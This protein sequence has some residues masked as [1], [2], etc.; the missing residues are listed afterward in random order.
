MP[1]LGRRELL[2][3]LAVTGALTGAGGLL[4]ACGHSAANPAGAA[5]SRTPNRGGNLKIGMSGGSSSDTLDPHQ[6]LT[7][8]DTG[9]FEALYQPLV[10]LSGTAAIEY[11]LAESITPNHG[12]LSEWIIKIRPGVAFHSGKD[13]TADDVV[14]TIQRIISKGFSGAHFFGPTDLKNVK[15]LDKLTVQVPMA[16]PFG[17]FVDQLAGGWYYLYVVPSGFDG[18][19]P[20]GTGPF[21]FQSF[22]P[23]QR[24]VFV[25]N[26]N[27]WKHGLPYA[28][29]LTIIDFSDNAAVQDALVT[30]SIQAAG[31]LD[32][33]Q[34]PALR[35]AS[36]VR[37]VASRTGQFKPFTMRIDQAPFNDVNVRQALR[38][39][40]DRQQL[41]NSALDGFGAVASDVFSPYDPGFDK[42]LHRQQDIPQAKSLLKKAGMENMT[43]TLTTSAVA[44][45]MVAMATVLAEQA[46][47]AG[48]TIKIHQVDPGTFFGANYLSWT[49]SQDY[50]S[51]AP[52]LN[53]VAQSF[54]GSSSPFNE[55]HSNNP[56]YESLYAQ[57]NATANPSTRQQIEHEMQQFDF[58]QG[59]YIIPTFMDTLDAYSDKIAGYATGSQRAVGEPLSNWDME[60]FWFV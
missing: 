18:K 49:F 55:T 1:E 16:S 33:P 6:G 46:A 48:V 36:G 50:Y 22:T 39:L 3:G 23:G 47:A 58:S 28:D 19:K 7:Y 51:Y 5:H 42:S 43:V 57:A 37:P 4:A 59:P 41:I 52:Y 15:A 35:N 17:S 32:P 26:K 9:R 60:H 44:T 40:V 54:L 2:R 12:S 29:A 14:Y 30:G 34:I 11:V 25:R 24:S 38:L 45:G 56:H 31:Q 10:K 21:A 53:Q 13:L 27:Y 20:D 8:L